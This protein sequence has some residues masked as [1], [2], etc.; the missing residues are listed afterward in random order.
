M[1]KILALS[2]KDSVIANE[3]RMLCR[4][5]IYTLIIKFIKIVL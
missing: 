4:G 1:L 5:K 2:C 3:C